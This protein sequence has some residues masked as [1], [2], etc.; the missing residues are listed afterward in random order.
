MKKAAINNLRIYVS[1]YNLFTFHDATY[2]DP[3]R[4]NSGVSLGQYPTTK[5]FIVGLDLTFL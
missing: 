1:G 5:S 2:W 4:G 3:E